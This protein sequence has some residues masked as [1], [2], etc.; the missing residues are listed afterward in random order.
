MKHLA[1]LVLL[2]SIYVN[3]NAQCTANTKSI[4]LGGTSGYVSFVNSTNL[5]LDSTVTLEAWIKPSTFGTSSFTNSI[6]CKHSSSQGK[7]GYVIR[8]GGT[9]QLSFAIAGTD[10]SGLVATWKEIISPI[11]TLSL[12]TW[13]HVAGVYDGDSLK[14]Y[15][16]TIEV[17]ATA[18]R[19]SIVPSTAFP[20]CIGR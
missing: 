10:S 16:N 13:Q 18:F 7:Q 2:C 9:G 17:G 11:N 15:L 1:T 6:I 8:C 14:I 20:L 3:C 12:N 4:L 19:G 5:S